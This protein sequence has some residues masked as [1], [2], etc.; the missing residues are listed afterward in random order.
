MNAYINWLEDRIRELTALRQSYAQSQR[1]DDADL[2]NIRINI[3]G[4][5]KSVWVTSSGLG[6]SA[7][8][9]RSKMSELSSHWQAAME[10]AK[11]HEDWTGAA[12]EEIKLEI[13]REAMAKFD[14]LGRNAE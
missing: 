14:S 11:A 12:V 1:Q 8:D 9:Y 4:I 7:E 5:C 6:R 2:T 13:F 10:E 3:L